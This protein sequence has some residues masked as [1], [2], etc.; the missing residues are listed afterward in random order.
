M[1][2]QTGGKKN[3]DVKDFKIAQAVEFSKGG[4]ACSG[5]GLWSRNAMC[6]RSRTET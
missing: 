2:G 3:K 6:F 5:Q 4:T 1:I